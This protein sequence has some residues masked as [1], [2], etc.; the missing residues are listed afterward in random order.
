MHWRGEIFQ[1]VNEH[2]IALVYK[3]LFPVFII[4]QVTN[5][6]SYI[7]LKGCI[8][9][10]K[11]HKLNKNNFIYIVLHLALKLVLWCVISRGSQRILDCKH[12]TWKTNIDVSKGRFNQQKMKILASKYFVFLQQLFLINYINSLYFFKN[13]SHDLK[14]W[15]CVCD[16][17]HVSWLGCRTV[18]IQRSYVQYLHLLRHAQCAYCSVTI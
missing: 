6:F 5:E 14:C 13:E 2:F 3:Q 16:V 15:T 12:V 1:A 10:I 17:I 18:L 4:F 8:S 9:T 11:L 7:G